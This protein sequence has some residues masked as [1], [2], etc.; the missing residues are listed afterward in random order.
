MNFAVKEFS[1]E[2]IKETLAIW[3][4]VIKNGTV[5]PQEYCLNTTSGLSFFNSQSYTGLA[6]NVD[7][8]EIVGVYILHPNNVGRCGHICNASY[9]V[10]E[11]LRG[12]RIGE[13][14]VYIAFYRANSFTL[15]FYS[16]MPLYPATPLLCAFTKN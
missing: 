8:N 16:L 13:A 4:S 2:N 12:Q 3:N 11:G 1:P 7:T 5:F 14:L 9:A 6:Y 10:K 15:K